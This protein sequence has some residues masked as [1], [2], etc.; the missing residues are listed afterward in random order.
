MAYVVDADISALENPGGHLNFRQRVITL[1]ALGAD[2]PLKMNA[3]GHY[4]LNAA[5]FPDQACVQASGGCANCP[6]KRVERSTPTSRSD[7]F[8]LMDVT[9]EIKVHPAGRGRPS[10]TL[11]CLDTKLVIEGGLHPGG[12]IPPSLRMDGAK[13]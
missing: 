2:I 4:N 13:S 11:S 6:G 5:D 3:V 1:E 9:S 10:L 12:K 8:Y 7:C